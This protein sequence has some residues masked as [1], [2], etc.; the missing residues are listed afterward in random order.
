MTGWKPIPLV[1]NVSS[2]DV[3]VEEQGV[4]VGGLKS[5]VVIDVFDLSHKDGEVWI[6]AAVEFE[7]V[8]DRCA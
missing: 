3:P 4:T 2:D 8:A 6:L 5:V 7:G 1:A